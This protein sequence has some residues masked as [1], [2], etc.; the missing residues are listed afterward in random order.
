M[1]LHKNDPELHQRALRAVATLTENKERS[2]FDEA[3]QRQQPLILGMSDGSQR[4][5]MVKSVSDYDVELDDGTRRKIEVLYALPTESAKSLKKVL[6]RDA[7]V[8]ALG[9]RPA[10]KVKDRPWISKMILQQII[11]DRSKVR[12]TLTD[13]STIPV[14]LQAFGK[15]EIYGDISGKAITLFRHGVYCLAVGDSVLVSFESRS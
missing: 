12:F 8:A 15:Y 5:I 11:D 14:R 3:H 4:K 13:G 9:L 10:E 6:K 1:N 7:R 2:I